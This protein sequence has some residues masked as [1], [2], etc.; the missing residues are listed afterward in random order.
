MSEQE[1]KHHHRRRKHLH[2][3][4]KVA[5]AIG[6][7]LGIFIIFGGITGGV[8]YKSAKDVKAEAATV[9]S[10]ID[11]LKDQILADDYDQA[12]ST[13]ANIASHAQKMK[14]ETDG[15]EWIV[16]SAIPVYG[17]DVANVCVLAS[18]FDD[19]AD[20]AV[21]PLVDA[22][23]DVSLDDLLVDKTVNI[24]QTQKVLDAIVEVAPVIEEA[25]DKVEA[26][27]EPK[28]EQI[29]SPLEKA[30]SALGEL[31]TA[32]RF[33]EKI[34]PSFATMLG[35]DNPRT[36]IIV[37]QNNSEI[38][39]TGGFLGSVGALHIDKG[40]IEMGEFGSVYKIYPPADQ[41]ASLTK[42]EL[43][44]FG[45]HVAYQVADSNF[46]PDFSRVGEIVEY[47]WEKAGRGSADGVIG[48]DP[49]FLQHM[50]A[51]VGSVTASDGTVVD[52]D[53]AAKI[54]LHDAYYIEN[55]HDQDAF[56]EE[57]ARLSFE[58]FMSRLG[59]VSINKMGK[60]LGTD[61]AERRLQVW[62][63][64]K[65]EEEAMITARVDGKLSHDAEHP[66]LGVYFI[67][68]SYSKLF[69]Y[70]K[71]DTEIGEPM[72]HPDGSKTY[73]VTVTYKNMIE[74][75]NELAR[76][77]WAHNSLARSHGDMMCW[78]MISAPEGGKLSGLTLLE[79]EFLP[80]GT[81]WRDDGSTISGTMT[82]TTLQDLDF[83]YG[84]THAQ[85]GETFSIA[86]YVTC[87]PEAT[88]ELSV[89][90]TPTAQEVA[91]W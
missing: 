72:D 47:S 70:L 53:N 77:A 86:F 49:V 17:A 74:D 14:D 11:D 61:I 65:V 63:K 58:K 13:A 23:S 25:A 78:V 64:D 57:V 50:L 52:G 4:E 24:E 12:K 73:P 54:L 20:D 3:K 82:Q 31:D 29:K 48:V 39:S 16:A 80:E 45:P 56:F 55:G 44:I 67:D 51:L 43:E 7:I 5:I 6:V 81:H 60:T 90:R 76:Y 66:T 15:W 68:E 18:T 40:H 75:E 22:L 1:H 26:M 79:G 9:M 87:P 33:S 34:A 42:E 69:W 27:E 59:S 83:W 71:V 41:A 46:I 91:G 62:M 36:Y 21:V 2:R 35:A 88:G 32:A 19:L 28:I 10:S 38:R 30:K 85:P 84:F 37:A 89:V 8:L